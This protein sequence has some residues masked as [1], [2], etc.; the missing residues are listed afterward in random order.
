MTRTE[1]Q[2][3]ISLMNKDT[4]IPDK[5]LADQKQQHTQEITYHDQ[6]GFIPKT[7]GSTFKN[8]STSY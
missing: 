1:N 5:I 7:K 2:R 6:L 4:K 8:Q 3:P